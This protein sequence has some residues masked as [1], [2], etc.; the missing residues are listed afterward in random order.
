M[1]IIEFIKSLSWEMNTYDV[2]ILWEWQN[3]CRVCG[4]YYLKEDDELSFEGCSVGG[5]QKR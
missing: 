2:F 5:F 4:F 1:T 3:R